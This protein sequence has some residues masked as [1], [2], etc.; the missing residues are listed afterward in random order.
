MI[1]SSVMYSY[2]LHILSLEVLNPEAAVA[3]A[4]IALGGHSCLVRPEVSQRSQSQEGAEG[5]L[6]R[7]L[8]T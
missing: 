3:R 2:T 5:T 1:T 8:V 7:M 4:D 6:L